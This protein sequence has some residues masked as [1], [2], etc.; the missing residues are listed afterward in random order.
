[1]KD[2]EIHPWLTRMIQG[3]SQA[4]HQIYQLTHNHV[5]RLLCFLLRN[6]E[7]AGDVM[8]E[9]YLNLIKALPSY[10]FNQSFQSWLNGLIIRQANNWRRKIWRRMRLFERAKSFAMESQVDQSEAKYLAHEQRSEILDLV[11]KLPY[12][13]REVIVLRHYQDCS[14]EEIAT[15]LLVPLGTVKSRLHSANRKLRHLVEHHY[16]HKEASIHAD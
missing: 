3:D 10:N 12:K 15:L 16:V 14:L 6:Q 7:D 8:S 4:F 9:V 2:H 13:L 5:Y 1:M 11:N